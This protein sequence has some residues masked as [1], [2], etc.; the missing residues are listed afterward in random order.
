MKNN[1]WEKPLTALLA[2]HRKAVGTIRVCKAQGLDMNPKTAK[3]I[4]Y[5]EGCDQ[6]VFESIDVLVSVA[7]YIDEKAMELRG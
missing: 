3:R 5:L 4:A 1:N 2:H 7:Q 6:R